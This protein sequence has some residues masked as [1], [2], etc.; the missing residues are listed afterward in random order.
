MVI[1]LLFRSPRCLSSPH[2]CTCSF[3]IDSRCDMFLSCPSSSVEGSNRLPR[4][5]IPT[6]D[7]C[8]DA[9]AAVSASATLSAFQKILSLSEAEILSSVLELE[10]SAIETAKKSADDLEAMFLDQALDAVNI[11]KEKMSRGQ[12]EKNVENDFLQVEV[13]GNGN[14]V[15]H[16]IFLIDCGL[17]SLLTS[18][19]AS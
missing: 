14:E 18:V 15:G 19:V 17:D 16:V 4:P 12:W 10:K 8:D 5:V 1:F 7:D 6:D 3:H 9:S 11:R 2:L 13:L